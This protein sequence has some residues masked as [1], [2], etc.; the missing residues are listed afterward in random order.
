MFEIFNIPPADPIDLPLTVGPWPAILIVSAY[1]LFVLKVGRQFM[2]HR[3]PYDLNKILKVYNLIQI[4]Y[5]GTLFILV[6]P[7]RDSIHV[8]GNA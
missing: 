2:E 7:V 1:L 3:Q 8:D 4:A 5:N 6:S